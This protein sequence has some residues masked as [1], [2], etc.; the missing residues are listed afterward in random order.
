MSASATQG[1]HN[2]SAISNKTGT[3]R[4]NTLA[5][6]MRAVTFRTATSVLR[7]ERVPSHQVHFRCTK[8]C[9]QWLVNQPSYSGLLLWTSTVRDSTLANGTSPFFRRRL[10]FSF[11]F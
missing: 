4:M 5:V 10:L 7:D 3:C 2:Y 6:D 1:G 11:E 9:H 8:K